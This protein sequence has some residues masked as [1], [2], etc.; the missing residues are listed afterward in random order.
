[1]ADR[2]VAGDAD[3]ALDLHDQPP[4]AALLA[5]VLAPF[6]PDNQ[7]FDGLTL[8]GAPLPPQHGF[9]LRL[10]VPN[11]AGLF[12]TKWLTRVEVLS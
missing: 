12:D 8:E 1:M 11:R 4:R 2:L 7:M 3:G 6:A 9:P 10:I 5:P